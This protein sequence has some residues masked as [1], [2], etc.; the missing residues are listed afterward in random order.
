VLAV[1]YVN[2]DFGKGGRDLINKA[3]EARGI[4]VGADVST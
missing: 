1:K 3:L 4:K 2:N